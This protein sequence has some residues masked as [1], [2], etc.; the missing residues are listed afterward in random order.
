MTFVDSIF[1]KLNSKIQYASIKSNAHLERSFSGL[2]DFD[3]LVA[4]EDRNQL[5]SI[6]Q[7]FGGISRQ[8]SVEK[9]YLSVESFLLHG[10][11][12]QGLIH[13]HIH[14]E[15]IFGDRFQKNFVIYTAAEL[16]A[17]RIVNEQYKIYVLPKDIELFYLTLRVILKIKP[18]QAIKNFL[19]LFILRLVGRRSNM[20]HFIDT[21]IPQNIQSELI[22]LDFLISKTAIKAGIEWKSESLRNLR[23]IHVFG[24]D[25][26]HNIFKKVSLK[27]LIKLFIYKRRLLAE[28][29]SN[30]EFGDPEINKALIK[31]RL[32]VSV[33][34]CTISRR[35]LN[36][37][38]IGVDG[39]GKSSLVSFLKGFFRRKTSCDSLYLGLQ[40]DLKVYKILCYF[41]AIFHKLKIFSLHLWVF[42]KKDRLM[43]LCRRSNYEQ[44]IKKSESG[45]IMFLDRFPFSGLTL[46]FK[47]YMDRPKILDKDLMGI[48]E[49]FDTPPD[50]II[51]LLVSKEVSLF[52]KPSSSTQYM[53]N[54]K[55]KTQMVNFFIENQLQELDS[56]SI[57]INTNELSE[58]E[59]REEARTFVWKLLL[60]E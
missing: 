18:S 51:V 47:S 26:L 9:E 8:C 20:P 58:G 32:S 21:L 44:A 28:L 27:C 50:G 31:D 46:N 23:K 45:Y 52:R 34:H 12:V 49:I 30:F 2:T 25:F 17:T 56:K 53:E 37:A 60:G 3:L 16:L 6:L 11:E 59:V 4:I 36:I 29:S 7:K 22:Y 55:N 10:S 1:K 39:S 38:V 33:E 15:Y 19:K 54:I 41:Q 13:F 40:R 35:G 57:I 24:L 43:G 14:Y 5:I 48:Y 42:R